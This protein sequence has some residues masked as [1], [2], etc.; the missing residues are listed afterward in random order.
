[1]AGGIIGALIAAVPGFIDMLALPSPVS[2]LRSARSINLTVV[3]A[4]SAS[5][6]ECAARGIEHPCGS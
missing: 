2:A 6:C 3:T 5:A 1:M 4:S